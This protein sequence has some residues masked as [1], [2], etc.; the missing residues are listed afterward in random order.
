[1]SEYKSVG[2]RLE[3]KEVQVE[4]CLKRLAHVIHF[5]RVVWRNYKQHINP[6]VKFAY[7]R[8]YFY[9]DSDTLLSQLE[10]AHRDIQH[11]TEALGEAELEI[12]QLRAKLGELPQPQPGDVVLGSKHNG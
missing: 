7:L 3:G 5:S 10:A 6:Q 11:L 9:A 8:G 12:Q 1:M 4:E 2:I